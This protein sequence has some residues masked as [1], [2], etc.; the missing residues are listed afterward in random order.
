MDG[1]FICSQTLT[2]SVF[3]V[4]YLIN[5]GNARSADDTVTSVISQQCVCVYV[6]D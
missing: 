5:S 6:Y 3:L 4:W 2:F 1:T